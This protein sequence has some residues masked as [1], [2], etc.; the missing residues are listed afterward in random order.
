MSRTPLRGVRRLFAVLAAVL[1]TGALT[2]PAAHADTPSLIIA[3]SVGDGPQLLGRPFPITLT[4][5]N[6]TDQPMPKVTIW[7]EHLSGS[8]LSVQDWA[9]LGGSPQ[10]GV[11]LDPGATRT[12]TITATVHTWNSGVPHERFRSDWAQGGD[13]VVPLLDPT[14]THGPA[15]GVLYGDRNE[16]GAFDAGEGLPGAVAYLYGTS[17]GN[18]VDVTTDADGR[19]AFTDLPAQRYGISTRDLPDG[20][21]YEAAAQQYLDVD[22]SDPG[23]A[24]QLRALRPF[25]EK[26][27][28]T[29]SF[30][31]GTYQAGDQVRVTFTV[32]NVS[33]GDL[34]GITAGCDRFGGPDHL[35]GWT[36]WAVAAPGGIDLAAGE[37]RTFTETGTVPS[38]APTYG[39]FYAACDFGIDPGPLDGRPEVD[40]FAHVPAPPGTTG[41]VI[42]HDDNSN[43]TVDAGE[44]IAGTPVELVDRVDGSV[45]ATAVSDAQGHVAFGTVPAG[46]Y[47]VRVDG[48]HEV[49]GDG[50]T[51]FVG[52]CGNCGEEWA[53][54][55]RH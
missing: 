17:S 13:L 9:G 16:N 6:P 28:A 14:T 4:L 8:W 12:F 3:A 35:L 30:D 48:W 26:V 32:T 24:V 55:Y 21:I 7:D 34:H 1:T 5:T 33:G 20:W 10:A 50:G 22:G 11:A 36:D 49:D 47:R 18:P 52:T 40:V 41:G 54:R 2:V 38:A 23:P 25:S 15:S 46:P 19:F 27:H 42:Y 37:T 51:L 45:T 29:G 43:Y 39:G 31:R 44:A 53:L